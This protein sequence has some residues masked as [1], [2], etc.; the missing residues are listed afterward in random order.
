MIFYLTLRMNDVYMNKSLQ[1]NLPWK[2]Y[3][4]NHY[5]RPSKKKYSPTLN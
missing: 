1:Q 4:E 5:F 2:L 3:G